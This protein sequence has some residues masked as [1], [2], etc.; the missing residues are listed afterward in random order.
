MT[1]IAFV[2]GAFLNN[3]EGQNFTFNKNQIKIRGFASQFPIDTNVPFPVTRLPSISDLDNLPVF[4][5]LDL[6]HKAVK[7]VSNRT[8]GDSQ[9]LFGLE[10]YVKAFDVV[11]TA[12][13]Y[14]YYSY[15]LAKMR[16]HKLI[17]KLVITYC[18]T[19]PHNNE[20]V[21]R[22]KFIKYKTMSQA[23]LFICHT[24]L[25]K[26]ALLIEGIAPEKIE[27]V[28]LGVDLTRFK[29]SIH[30]KTSDMTILFV[31]RLVPEKGILD[32]YDAFKMLKSSK[33]YQHVYLK[34]VG[35]GALKDRIKKQIKIDGLSKWISIET[36]SYRQMPGVYQEADIFVLPSKH[37]K[38]W[39]EQYGMV[40]VEALACG[41]PIISTQS[42][43]IPEVIGPAGMLVPESSADKLFSALIKMVDNKDLRLQLSKM[44]YARALTTYDSRR[45]AEI[46]GTIYTRLAHS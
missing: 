45:T 14:Y 9:I 2:R 4:K 40:L 6:Y 17:K 5:K 15:Q 21:A 25:S 16:K 26:N 22:K 27:I 33:H 8:L 11:D 44:S 31:G 28:R 46:I 37:T 41:L 1:N 10:S 34:I 3:F 30:R 43:A 39:E 32:L 23:D 36:K 24:E 19:I 13:P 38:T 7:Y 42:G 18:E 35:D 12:D 20:T 29:R